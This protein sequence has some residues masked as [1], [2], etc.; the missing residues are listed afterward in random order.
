MRIGDILYFS[1]EYKFTDLNWDNRGDL[2]TAFKDRVYG[3]YL[4]P[5]EE[6]G[7]NNYAFAT[8]VICVTVIDFIAR[9]TLGRDHFKQWLML[10]I[11]QFKDSD[12]DNSTRKLADR[13]YC[14]FRN[15]LVHEGRIKNCGQFS[16]KIEELVSVVD[17]VM[18]VNPALLLSNIEQA[19][20]KYIQKIQEDQTT[21][22]SFKTALERDFQKDVEL[23]R[24]GN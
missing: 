14:E 10:N 24:R 1:P 3:F 6:L 18:I 5:A 15:G 23:A 21:F 12:P 11:Q 19:F 8:G 22:Q 20:K 17:G 2:T 4:K 9:I 16:Y 7:K 13:F